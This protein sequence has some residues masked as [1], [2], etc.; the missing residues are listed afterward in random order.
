[1]S[2]SLLWFFEG[3]AATSGSLWRGG[4]RYV[5]CAFPPAPHQ[6]A[7]RVLIC[8]E[9][10]DRHQGFLHWSWHPA[11]CGTRGCH[12]W[13]LQPAVWLRAVCAVSWFLTYGA[14]K[15]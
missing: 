2:L 5:F 4:V 15:R 3:V 13:G 6:H 7:L 11:S 9:S 14:A 10:L 1:M 12:S 8:T